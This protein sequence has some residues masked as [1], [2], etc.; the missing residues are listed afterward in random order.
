MHA[1]TCLLF[2]LLVVSSS[3]A[4]I[5]SENGVRIAV[6]TNGDIDDFGWSNTVNTG[7][8]LMERNLQISGSY[9]AANILNEEQCFNLMLELVGKGYYLII[10][11]TSAHVNAAARAARLYPNVSFVQTGGSS[12]L[13]NLSSLG[14][15]G[16][17]MYYAA[18]TFCGAM[19][20]NNKI[21][22][23][24]PGPPYASV[25]TLNAFYVGAKTANPNV[26]VY[27]VFT[28]TFLD[29]D[30]AAGA[31]EILL[32]QGV[33]MLAGQQ[34][35][36]T[37]QNY[38]M[39]NGFLAVGLNGYSLRDIFGEDIGVSMVRNWGGPLTIYGNGT[40]NATQYGT[41]FK[42]DI[43][44]AFASGFT[45]LDTLSYRVPD[46]VRQ[47]LNEG[48]E[49]LKLPRKPYFCSPWVSEM[50]LNPN[51][52][53]L[54]NNTVFTSYAL[55][56]IRHLGTY[57]VPLVDVPF[58]QNTALAIT[59]LSALLLIFPCAI[60][61]G[62]YYLRRDQVMLAASPLF[63]GL[64]LVGSSMVYI[65]AITWALTPTEHVCAARIWLPSIGATLAMG[66]MII[67]NIRLWIIFDAQ[68]RRVKIRDTK[69][70]MWTS[71]LLIVDF[72]L[73]ALW[74]GLGK[75]RVDDQQG[76][77]G[78]GTYE[79]RKICVTD[80]IGDDLLWAIIAFHISQL[81][82]GCYVTFKIRVIDI[83]EFNESR[84]F[85][86]CIYIVSLCFIIAGILIGTTGSTYLQIVVIVAFSFLI[87]ASAVLF[88]L[89]APKFLSIFTVGKRP[90]ERIVRSFRTRTNTSSGNSS[91][92]TPA[93]STKT[94]PAP[95]VEAL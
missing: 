43:P 66:V 32:D 54:V 39:D 93:N 49:L 94:K 14:W 5:D 82:V 74:T 34:D 25:G 88:M 90:I 83:E 42:R 13:P 37:V 86:L 18:G 23:V 4:D 17:D 7:R 15:N 53:C 55:T 75:P 52:S 22:F 81:A 1:A 40:I 26:E 68:L 2:V 87:G 12:T 44:A 3:F 20:T 78:L 35:D 9:F 62:L 60:A 77:D 8:V 38:A 27:S 64:V 45:Y 72:I 50:G 41:V 65:A 51:T 84:P 80:E 24:H 21:G 10:S 56:S 33:T 59:V 48:V 16:P 47:L 29:P 89:F 67:K 36:F 19:T 30:R 71:S 6:I 11:A 92:T 28:D 91:N 76:K 57:H 70:L 61:A 46:N 31:C 69:L 85:G 95:A 63:L 79:V 58:P 73:L